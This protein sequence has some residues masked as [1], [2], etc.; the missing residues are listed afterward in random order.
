MCV[1]FWDMES[2]DR[3]FLEHT[4]MRNFQEEKKKKLSREGIMQLEFTNEDTVYQFYKTYAMI[5][6]FAMRLDEVRR[7]SD[8]YRLKRTKGPGT[9]DPELEVGALQEF[10]HDWVE[11]FLNE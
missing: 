5:H 1:D 4:L 3:D 10:V 7:D 6:D 11:N 8:D 9:T 2:S